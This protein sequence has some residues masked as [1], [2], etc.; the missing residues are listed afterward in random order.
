MKNWLKFLLIL[1]V[2]LVILPLMM[3]MLDKPKDNGNPPA[4]PSFNKA[5]GQRIAVIYSFAGF[6]GGNNY[7]DNFH[8]HQSKQQD[9]AY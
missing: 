2:V 4:Q 6:D 3:V 8:N 7:K 5:D 1:F 9:K